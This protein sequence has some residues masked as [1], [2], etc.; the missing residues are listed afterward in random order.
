L[1]GAPVCATCL[2]EPPPFA[3][4]VVA[5]D[6][7]FPW[8]RLIAD[9]KFAGHTELAI[10]LADRLLAALGTEEPG[11]RIDLVLPVPLSPQRLA[12]RG[13]NQAWLLARRVAAALGLP[14]EAD[15]LQ[16]PIA[17]SHQAD[18]TRAERQKNL[19]GAFMVDPTRRARLAGLRVA[20]VDDVMT[21]G[22]TLREASAE[23]LRAG[24]VA[25]EAW[26]VA[27]TP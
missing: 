19:R 16:R 7:A 5:V 20:L 22:A 11:M 3:R 23:L 13:Y 10:P 2:R 17:T 14:A 15:L 6:Y 4:A 27:R 12:E 21:T 18:L 9:L 25:V 24:A 1:Q 8:D 26:A